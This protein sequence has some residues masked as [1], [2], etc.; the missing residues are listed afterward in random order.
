MRALLY[1]Q[2]GAFRLVDIKGA[3]KVGQI[4]LIQ[5]G[6]KRHTT[7]VVPI[8]IPNSAYCR[9]ILEHMQLH[10]ESLISLMVWITH[11]KEVEIEVIEML[12]LEAAQ[13]VVV[14]GGNTDADRDT[15]SRYSG[16][17]GHDQLDDD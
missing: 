10:R 9:L 14:S 7:K 6:D 13:E 5:S 17:N 11:A 15:D 1:G 2:V 3:S 8:Y 16:D 4:D 12:A